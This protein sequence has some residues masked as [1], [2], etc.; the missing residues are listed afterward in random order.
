MVRIIAKEFHH[1]VMKRIVIWILA[2]ALLL[3][4]CAAPGQVAAPEDTPVPTPAPTPVP[5]PRPVQVLCIA[6][7][8]EADVPEYFAAIR[9]H[10]QSLHWELTFL[11]DIGGFDKAVGKGGYEGIIALRS[12]QENLLSV[13]GVMAKSGIPVT[14]VDM[15]LSAPPAGVSYA[16]YEE[17]EL[18]PM[19][20]ETAIAYPPHDTPVRMF[21]IFSGEES[22]AAQAY[23]T[24]VA[25]G[26]IMDRAS[27]YENGEQ[28]LSA[29]L[30]KQLGRWP[31]GMVDAIFVENMRMAMETLQ[32]LRAHGREDMEVF[33]VPNRNV[34]EQRAA[35]HK[36]VFPAAFGPDLAEQARLQV[37]EMERLLGGEEPREWEFVA[38]VSLQGVFQ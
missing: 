38:K 23:A 24:S 35:Y 36:Y 7:L 9:E 15:H 13:F 20:L 37:E 33:A 8:A 28:A 5:T 12:Q 14:I 2:C 18:L 17:G 34:Q 30:E 22:E 3:G 11:E 6:D 16:F 32:V 10:A 19:V 21:G 29:F 25:G 27:Y 4:G 1:S 26:R 31:E